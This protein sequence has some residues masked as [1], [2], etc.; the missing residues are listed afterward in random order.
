[1]ERLTGEPMSMSTKRSACWKPV[2]VDRL[3]VARP[4]T[5]V[6]SQKQAR[7]SGGGEAGAGTR[8]GRTSWQRR[9]RRGSRCRRSCTFRWR[10]RRCPRRSAELS[11]S[12]PNGKRVDTRTGVACGGKDAL[13]GTVGIAYSSETDHTR[14]GRQSP[15]FSSF[16]SC[17]LEGSCMTHEGKEQQVKPE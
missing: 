10:R 4:V 14:A 3:I 11:V 12:Q 16:E 2:S 7:W 6:R 13:R 9:S 8:K 17:P 1:M 5:L 15:A